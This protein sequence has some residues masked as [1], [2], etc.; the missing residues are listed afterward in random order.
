MVG[1]RVKLF[2]AVLGVQQAW[3]RE[4]TVGRRGV[5]IPLCHG[6]CSRAACRDKELKKGKRRLWEEKHS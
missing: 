1:S 2:S 6:A 3:G 5:F 4:Y